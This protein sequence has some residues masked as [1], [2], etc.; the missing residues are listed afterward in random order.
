MFFS[1]L[2]SY[3]NFS[4]VFREG[5]YLYCLPP[6]AVLLDAGADGAAAAI[7]PFLRG[8]GEGLR[9]AG[10]AGVAEGLLIRPC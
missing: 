9:R 1:W 4:G 5:S 8:G 6:L 3:G 2:L 7:F 10:A